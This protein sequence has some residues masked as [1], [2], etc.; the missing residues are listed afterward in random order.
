MQAVVGTTVLARP[1]PYGCI[2][3]MHHAAVVL[4][5]CIQEVVHR[6]VLQ[7]VTVLL[8]V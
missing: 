5:C 6:A 8:T 7:L 4:Q 2:I 3:L 1:K